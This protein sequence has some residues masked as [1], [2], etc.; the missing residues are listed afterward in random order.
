MAFATLKRLQELGHLTAFL[1]SILEQW[2]NAQA[3]PYLE[4][5]G[6]SSGV[7]PLFPSRPHG[8]DHD[9]PSDA[10]PRRHGA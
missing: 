7:C 10:E 8:R 4:P 9:L 6:M 3:L 2:H 1:T 5:N